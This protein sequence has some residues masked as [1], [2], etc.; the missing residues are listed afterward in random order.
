MNRGLRQDNKSGVK[1]VSWSK[2]AGRWLAHVTVNKKALHLGLFE[3]IEE[4]KAARE[5]AADK[6]HGKFV[7][8]R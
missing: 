2:K 6:L 3:T 7:R 4:A 5:A 8:H 1:G